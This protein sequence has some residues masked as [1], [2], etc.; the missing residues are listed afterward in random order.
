MKPEVL[1]K[2]GT[3]FFTTKE[4]GTGLGL[5]VCHGI[6]ERHNATIDV[7][8]SSAGTTFFVRFRTKSEQLP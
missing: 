2:L 6:A 4:T 1:E 5:A 8:T 7:E 3:P